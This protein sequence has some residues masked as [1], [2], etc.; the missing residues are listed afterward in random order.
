VVREVSGSWGRRWGIR[1]CHDSENVGHYYWSRCIN[2][3]IIESRF[4]DQNQLP[5]R[6]HALRGD[7]GHDATR[8]DYE[9]LTPRPARQSLSR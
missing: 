9:V 6:P 3:R 2:G 5:T 4:D 1:L 8:D 7:K